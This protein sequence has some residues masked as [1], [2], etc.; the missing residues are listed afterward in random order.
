MQLIVTQ[1]FE[2]YARG[3][4]I[5]D[6]AEIAAVLASDHAGHVV[7]TAPAPAVPAAAAR[8]SRRLTDL[9]KE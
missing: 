5:T 9:P 8:P 4:A 1:A 3:D 6:P 7:P 2:A